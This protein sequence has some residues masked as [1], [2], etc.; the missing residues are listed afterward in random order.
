MDCD[1]IIMART[2]TRQVHLLSILPW[3]NMYKLKQNR[4]KN[5]E[6]ELG[7]LEV[8]K[9]GHEIDVGFQRLPISSK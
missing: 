4:V 3:V 2:G 8:P 9:F 7:E 6:D 1:S 5:T